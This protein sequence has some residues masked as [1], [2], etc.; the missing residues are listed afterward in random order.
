MKANLIDEYHFR[1]CPLVLGS[2]RPLFETTGPLHFELFGSKKYES[3][4][5][6]LQ[7]RQLQ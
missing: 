5:M 6:L 1:I 7:Y 2:G 4:L 3:G